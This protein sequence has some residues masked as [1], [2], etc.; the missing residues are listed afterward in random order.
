[1][2]KTRSDY[3]KS[4]AEY[5]QAFGGMKKKDL[6]EIEKNIEPA[7][8]FIKTKGEE[9]NRNEF[10]KELEK[11]GVKKE[12]AEAIYKTELKK[13]EYDAAKVE[14]GKKM[15]EAGVEK[16]EIFQKLFLKERELLN[17]VKV[18]SWP[19]K[20]KGIFRRGMEC[21]MKL[22]RAARIAGSVVLTTG[23]LYG[24][25]FAGVTILGAK[26][27][28]GASITKLAVFGGAR[29]GRALAGAAVGQI[30]AKGVEKVFFKNL[31]KNKK[32]D[33]KKIEEGFFA[34]DLTSEKIKEFEKKRDDFFETYYKKERNKN[35]VKA[36]TAVIAGAGTSIGLGF[37]EQA[38]AGGGVKASPDAIKPKVAVPEPA[39][40]APETPPVASAVEVQEGDTVWKLAE[41]QLEERGLFEGRDNSQKINFINNVKNIIAENPEKFGISSGDAD[42][43]HAGEKIDFKDIFE[44]K[45]MLAQLI[46]KSEHLRPT[47]AGH[48]LENAPGPKVT[49]GVSEKVLEYFDQQS[50][51]EKWRTIQYYQNDID[52]MEENIL[53]FKDHPE[54]V[55][56]IQEQINHSK[57]IR[58][59]LIKRLADQTEQT[60]EPVVGEAVK[61][62]GES[63]T[64]GILPKEKM[65]FL[66]N[67][68]YAKDTVLKPESLKGFQL[69]I[70]L[71]QVNGGKLTAEDFAKYYADKVGEQVS[72][73][74]VDGFKYNFKAMSGTNPVEKIKAEGVM[75]AFLKQLEGIR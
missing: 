50:R 39:P 52:A 5:K 26:A 54:T 51:P 64:E 56:S 1:L 42:L 25:G 12:Q 47:G 38:W 31:E 40:Q 28:V 43:I 13:A 57:G 11:K 21:W 10:V 61:K 66:D 65:A 59:S 73:E 30:V 32:E 45:N 71:I 69:Q 24:L 2:E 75:A 70:L 6:A 19:P 9:K 16:G 72:S 14:L 74:M 17:Q 62:V 4:Y 35:I 7:R 18:E 41:K 20:E 22:P 29:F 53:K 60:P 33:L 55:A 63:L 44:N 27:L 34:S 15:A 67:L 8:K 46:D 37:L 68:I 23:A 49:G 58:D 3:V 36:A 48:I